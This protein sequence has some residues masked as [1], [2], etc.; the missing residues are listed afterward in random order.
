M[1][2]RQRQLTIESDSDGEDIVHDDEQ[3]IEQQ[4]KLLPVKKKKTDGKPSPSSRSSSSSSFSSAIASEQSIHSYNNLINATSRLQKGS[5]SLVSCKKFFDFNE[6]DLNDVSDSARQVI[7]KKIH[8]PTN[9]VG[10]ITKAER[11]VFKKDFNHTETG[12]EIVVDIQFLFDLDENKLNRKFESKEINYKNTSIRF[13]LPRRYQEK[14]SALNEVSLLVGGLLMSPR[15]DKSKW[16]D[17]DTKEKSSIPLIMILKSNKMLESFGLSA[18]SYPSLNEFM[19][20]AKNCLKEGYHIKDD[21]I[22]VLFDYFK[23]QSLQF[24]AKESHGSNYIK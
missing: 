13:H 15:H 5:M 14:F 22:R 6:I 11:I 19:S 10:I 8:F 20:E 23:T 21:A 2:K 24:L 1:S 3:N 7:T 4:I 9:M 12:G 17:K 18:S 16:N